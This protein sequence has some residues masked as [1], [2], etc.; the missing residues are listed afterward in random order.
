M[1]TSQTAA[2]ALPDPV[3]QKWPRTLAGYREPNHARSIVEIVLRYK[4]T[5]RGHLLPR[6][7]FFGGQRF[8]TAA[9]SRRPSIDPGMFISVIRMRMSLRDS[10]R[11]EPRKELKAADER[12]PASPSRSRLNRG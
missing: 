1:Q 10:S 3:T 11:F 2:L 12:E 4:L 8:L 6:G 5:A 7:R 9:A